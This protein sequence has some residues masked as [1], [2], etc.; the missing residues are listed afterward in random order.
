MSGNMENP[1]APAATPPSNTG[2]PVVTEGVAGTRRP[3]EDFFS[4][5]QRA[6]ELNRPAPPTPGFMGLTP[7]QRGSLDQLA[8]FGAALASTRSP[9]F[10]GAFGEGIR[11][12]QQTA[13]GQRTE[14]RQERQDVRQ[15][16]QVTVE[17]AYR[18]AQE[19]RQAAELEYARDPTNPRNQL[20]VAQT[21]AAE[22]DAQ[23]RLM[24]ARTA[25]QSERLGQG[26]VTR[27]PETGA[28]QFEYPGA[29]GGSQVRPLAG[30]PVGNVAALR[31]AEQAD[32]TA[33]QA[34]MRQ[35]EASAQNSIRLSGQVRTPEEIRA[36]S[37]AAA[38]EAGIAEATR[39]GVDPAIIERMGSSEP[40]ASPNV[41][42]RNF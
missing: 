24:Q 21:R 29:Q 30:T 37:Q 13:A 1:F 3:Y 40:A 31:R 11:A 26:L 2:S 14:A 33:I 9:T 27:N 25:A 4:A 18:A 36:L 20:L 39:R 28:Y 16:Q 41:L 35:A 15:Q 22:A 12:L 17:A 32:Q 8:S 7:D 6:Q 5:Y 42:R 38:R 19:S 34:A 23:A 10:S